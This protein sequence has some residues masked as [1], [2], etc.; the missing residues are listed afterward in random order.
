LNVKATD[1]GGESA[2]SFTKAFEIHIKNIND[3]NPTFPAN[4]STST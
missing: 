4:V 2:R 3:N 1:G